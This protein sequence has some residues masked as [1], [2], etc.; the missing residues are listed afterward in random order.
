VVSIATY[1]AASG[2]AAGWLAGT[3]LAGN[4]VAIGAIAGAISGFATGVVMSGTLKSGLQGAFSGA[5][6]GAIKGRWDLRGMDKNWT[7]QRVGEESLAG[8]ISAVIS[9]RKF[10]DG[11]KITFIMSAIKNLAIT[12]REHQLEQS[13]KIPGQIGESNGVYG[14]P[15][16]LGG[17]RIIAR[18]WK[19]MFGVDVSEDA[20]FKNHLKKYLERH[21][22]RSPLG[23][24][25]GG[26][27]YLFGIK[28]AP[29]GAIDKIIESYAGI[30]DFLNSPMYRHDGV[31]YGFSE[32][33]FGTIGRGID[34]AINAVNVVIATPLV[35]IASIPDQARWIGENIKNDRQH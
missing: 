4:A 8:G 16:K 21:D 24:H 26:E 1:G 19:K 10:V 11:F 13:A 33:A 5:M 2:W 18:A 3:A 32:R 9:G 34:S 7:W 29:N 31:Y 30:H 17:G 14:R 35:T 28:Y 15:G 25:Q 12:A 27:G 20:D 6:F 23:G 22:L